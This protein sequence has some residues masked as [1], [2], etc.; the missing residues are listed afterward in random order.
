MKTETKEDFVMSELQ[1][2]WR[3]KTYRTVDGR[4][5]ERQS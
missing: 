2:R 1:K 3:K 4:D 5:K